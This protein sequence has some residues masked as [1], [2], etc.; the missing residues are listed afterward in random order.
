MKIKKLNDYIIRIN[1]QTY[2]R[3]R[4][5]TTEAIRETKNLNKV[6]HLFENTTESKILSTTLKWTHRNGNMCNAKR[7]TFLYKPKYIHLHERH[8]VRDTILQLFFASFLLQARKNK[9]IEVTTSAS[10]F[11]NNTFNTEH[12]HLHK[13]SQY[14]T[15][16]PS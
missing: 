8:F 1:T 12:K 5:K 6:R 7:K 14:N 9:T 16:F 15:C 2:L 10:L 3:T 4:Q 11:F 13:I